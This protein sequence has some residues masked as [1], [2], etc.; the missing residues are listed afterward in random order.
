[1]A[2]DQASNKPSR[3]RLLL[4]GLLLA[5]VVIVAGVVWY[6]RQSPDKV[7]NGKKLEDWVADLK[8]P[9]PEDNE[10]ASQALVSIGAEAVPALL[11]AR[12]AQDV[13]LQ[14]QASL[15]L[16]HMGE[17]AAAELV[18]TLPSAGEYDQV[19]LLR[20][21]ADALGPLQE[22][23]P[24]PQL[25]KHAA[26]VLGLFGPRAAPTVP[27]LLEVAANHQA[28][29]P[30]RAEAVR[31]L[32]RIVGSIEPA[33]KGHAEQR[34]RVT[35]A[36]LAA[37]QDGSAPVRQRAAE[38]LG[39]LEPQGKEV[40]A[41]LLKATKDDNADVVGAACVALGRLGRESALPELVRVFREGPD[42]PAARAAEALVLLGP[43][44]R[45]SVGKLLAGLKGSR[46][47]AGRTRRLL[48]RLG[49]VAV[50]GL[51]AALEEK[52]DAEVR[53][54]AVEVLGELG[55]VAEHASK[56]LLRALRDADHTVALAAA[57]ALAEVDPDQA[58]LG[59]PV[60]MK[61]LDDPDT[62]MALAAI[63][64][65]AKQ[66]IPDLIA[67]LRHREGVANPQKIQ[68]GAQQALAHIG[69]AALGPLKE[70]LAQRSDGTAARAALVLGTNGAA[71]RDAV[72]AILNDLKKD[73]A[74]GAA[75]ITALGM[76]GPSARAAV[77]EL[78]ALLSDAALRA[79]AAAA[80]ALIDPSLAEKAAA[81]L[82]PDLKPDPK[83]AEQKNLAAALQAMAYV[84][85]AGHDALP[86]LLALWR[87]RYPPLN[88][89]V[90]QA[91]KGI[92]SE[93]AP[94]LNALLRDAD[95]GQR[96]MAANA[97][98]ILGAN[99]EAAIPGLAEL[100]QTSQPRTIR[101]LA[102][103]ALGEMGEKAAPAVAGL[104]EQAND[105]ETDPR[106]EAVRTLG[107]IGP[108]A[109]QARLV[110]RDCLIDPSS[111]VRGLAALALGQVDP[112]GADNAP[113]LEPLR[114]DPAVQVRF[115]ALQ[116][117]QKITPGRAGDMAPQLRDLARSAEP[118]IHL[119]ALEGLAEVD[120]K[121]ARE[122]TDT[123]ERDLT[124]EDVSLRVRAAK[125][126]LRLQ[127]GRPRK[128]I[129]ALARLLASPVGVVRRQTLHLLA[130][131]G[132]KARPAV[133]WIVR[134]LYD[135]EKEIREA[136]ARAL[137]HLDRQAAIDA[138]V[139]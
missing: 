65:R 28:A 32:G 26:Q 79:P 61:A 106:R 6:Y 138:G 77:P 42:R 41:A 49:P 85:P 72:D 137:P 63:G 115:A 93:A 25:G 15:T 130:D 2:M 39:E 122:H 83:D 58:E 102:A 22:A 30:V 56:A 94:A 11:Q 139:H 10:R 13:H 82:K 96:E 57:R 123:L 7:Y 9:S 5:A 19:I 33:P 136:A 62:F 36:L 51:A 31:A 81:A 20:M 21:G 128:A 43:A 113:A 97:L 46:E 131:Q 111:E 45:E 119:P 116:A 135:Q 18:K 44:V 67:C 4:Q 84:G 64:P 132:S 76:I 16:V 125:L 95:P 52:G 110:L 90:N 71:A 86:E 38:A 92:G 105:W 134:L 35:A 70:A 100:L 75:Y 53:R 107:K 59:V 1:M 74:N 54:A 117:L 47:E 87:L 109:R 3:Q 101:T 121:A 118:S 73:R 124:L 27:A 14:R 34:Q 103:M 127:P 55:P 88:V 24:D 129:L 133:P 29:A 104:M 80:L 17:P 60:L 66:A 50:P 98:G 114:G 8:S 37:L 108:Q 120:E 69:P 112:K 48:L 91:I 126:L 78:T 89:L 68:L 12:Q 99:G 40:E 23:L